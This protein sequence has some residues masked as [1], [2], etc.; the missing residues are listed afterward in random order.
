MRAVETKTAVVT[1]RVLDPDRVTLVVDDAPVPVALAARGL[2]LSPGRH[3]FRASR[4]GEAITRALEVSAG[5]KVELTF[6]PLP[7][8]QPCLSPFP[9]LQP[10]PPPETEETLLRVQ[11]GIGPILG[12]VASSPP[13]VRGGP[14][15]M[16]EL[17]VQPVPSFWIGASVFGGAA[18]TT[19]AMVGFVG[20]GLDFEYRP[21]DVFGFGAGFSGGYL[22]P[23]E[24]TDS[25]A[26][27]VGDTFFGP[28]LVPASIFAGLFYMEARV[29]IW[30]SDVRSPG[31]HLGV[32]MVAPQVVFGIGAPVMER[33]REPSVQAH[34]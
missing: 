12:I 16:L 26:R 1:V 31:L 14:I 18:F 9:C 2:R 15:G 30:F 8:P 17:A 5:E 28:F 33:S 32:A 21:V 3:V 34:R 20:P 6:D 25:G 24:S 19:D 13:S 7:P 23:L 22:H 11:G 10:P 27:L 29:P 4:D